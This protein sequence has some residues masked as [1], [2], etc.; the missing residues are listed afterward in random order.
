[1][2]EPVKQLPPLTVR[3]S[4]NLLEISVNGRMDDAAA[5]PD[6]ARSLLE[7][8]LRYSHKRF[9]YGA[10]RYHPVTG[11]VR[12][13]ETT[14]K[15]FY[16][17]DQYGRLLTNFGFH[18]R[19]V[20]L[21]T[22]HYQ[23]RFVNKDTPL[24]QRARPKAY[25]FHPEN[26]LRHFT[27]RERQEECLIALAS[28]PCGVVH[29]VTGFGK[30]AMLAMH[31]LAY[32]N[33]KTD[34]VVRRAALAKKTHGYLTRYIP[35]VG[36]VGAGSRVPGDRVTVYTAASLHHADPW[37]A[38]F[39]LCDEAHE[40][41]ADDA[42]KCIGRYAQ[43]RRFAFSASVT[44]RSDGTDMR[45]ESLFGEVV[46][47]LPY[48]EA[49]EKGLVVPIRVEW[50]D[51]RLPHNPALNLAD[52]EKQR[53]GLW[54]NRERNAVI[55]D[56]ANSFADDD[57]VLILVNTVEHAVYLRQ[58]LPHFTMVYAANEIP[59]WHTYVKQGLIGADEEPMTARRIEELRIAF[60]AGT[61]KKVLATGVWAV[62]IDP[63]HLTAVI[64]GSAGS[65]EI[66]DIQAPGRVSRRNDL[67]CR[68]TQSD[69]A[70]KQHGIVCDFRDQFDPGFAAAAKRRFGHYAAMRWE[71]F[72]ITPQG[73][74]PLE[75]A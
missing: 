72:L 39:L 6:L 12:R 42:V 71:Q 2:N 61:L 48:W 50:T 40:L 21:L 43:A 74:V 20:R 65:S 73:P 36:L 22:P 24:A 33:A 58:H 45:M 41:L 4:G 23:L 47:H 62:G 69:I 53:H 14:E 9:L 18:A 1:M 16:R 55:A 51:V 56:R 37:D 52:V 3:K 59:R 25:D 26:V 10:E 64:R 46:F 44:G 17:Y 63:V 28:N 66:M 27:F 29:A 11:H 57:Q 8:Q 15:Q 5:L 67:V 38:D 60:E 31:T 7:G 32:P 30:M 35:C 34:I 54:R 70:V 75:K 19:I 68:E 49:A 13:V